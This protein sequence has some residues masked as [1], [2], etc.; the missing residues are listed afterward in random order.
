ML[1]Y[2]LTLHINEIL[3]IKKS[4]MNTPVLLLKNNFRNLIGKNRIVNGKVKKT[5]KIRKG[6]CCLYIIQQKN[7]ISCFQVRLLYLLR[8]IKTRNSS[9][10][11]TTSIAFNAF[12]RTLFIKCAVLQKSRTSLQVIF[13]QPHVRHV[14]S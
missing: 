7:A 14:R 5:N 1:N 13:K 10:F 2:Q 4:F 3:H 12:N 11:Y 6:K 8:V 9:P